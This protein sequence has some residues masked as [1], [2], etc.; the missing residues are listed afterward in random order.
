MRVRCIQV[1]GGA[2]RVV[3]CRNRNA[4]HVGA[5]CKRAR[6]SEQ[7]D[8]SA[9]NGRAGGQTMIDRLA[10]VLEHVEELPPEVQLE[11]SEQIEAFRRVPTLP[12]PGYAPRRSFAG[13]WR[14]LPDDM[15][16]TLLRW[17]RETAPLPSVE[18]QSR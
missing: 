18:D 10:R 5:R 12:A 7:V 16:E 17:R 3:S 13:I 15:E 2:S 9:D 6:V 14:D 11:L 1:G 8:K 4:Q